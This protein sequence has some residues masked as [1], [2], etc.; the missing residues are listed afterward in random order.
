[1]WATIYEYRKHG[2]SAL[3]IDEGDLTGFENLQAHIRFRILHNYVQCVIQA[4]LSC[5]LWSNT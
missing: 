5:L 4:M 1:M 3:H 2:L